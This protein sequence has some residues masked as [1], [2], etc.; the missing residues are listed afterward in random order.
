M[1]ANMS[2][3]D[4]DPLSRMVGLVSRFVYNTPII[5][6]L[7]RLWGTQ[8]VD[9]SNLKRLLAKNQN[10]GLVPGGFEEATLTT[11][12]EMRIYI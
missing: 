2:Y 6:L 10:V 7:L 3:Q 12:K 5:G 8:P 9:P 1:L 4:N 11:A